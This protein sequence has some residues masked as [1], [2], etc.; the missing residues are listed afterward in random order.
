MRKAKQP[1]ATPT[2]PP[3]SGSNSAEQAVQRNVAVEEGELIS[4]KSLGL[5][6][7]SL[8]D[9]LQPPDSG[10]FFSYTGEALLG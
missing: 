6:P 10:G 3:V 9:V 5:T 8:S 2:V 7:H 1:S 4:V